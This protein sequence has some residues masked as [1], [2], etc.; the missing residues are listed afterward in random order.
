MTTGNVEHSYQDYH[1]DI[2]NGITWQDME[3]I[4]QAL[5]ADNADELRAPLSKMTDKNYLFQVYD[6]LDPRD[7]TDDEYLSL[8]HFMS[9]LHLAAQLGSANCVELLVK[10][11]LDVN[12][13]AKNDNQIDEFVPL[14]ALCTRSF[15]EKKSDFEKCAEILLSNGADYTLRLFNDPNRQSAYEFAMGINIP[16]VKKRSTLFEP[17]SLRNKTADLVKP[18]FEKFM[19]AQEEKSEYSLDM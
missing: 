16:Q 1:S 4:M 12:L 17:T 18:A 14:H 5:R 13:Y 10:E 3:T 6:Y 19:K 8:R 7:W 15:L 2:V 9:I 11:G